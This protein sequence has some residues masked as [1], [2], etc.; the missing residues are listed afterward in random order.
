[1]P[2]I[3]PFAGVIVLDNVNTRAFLRQQGPSGPLPDFLLTLDPGATGA[4]D[5]AQITA[6]WQHYATMPGI[7][8]GVSQIVFGGFFT[9]TPDGATVILHIVNP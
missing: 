9:F 8:S 1:M 4:L 5:L 7:Q 3:V 6:A 2:D